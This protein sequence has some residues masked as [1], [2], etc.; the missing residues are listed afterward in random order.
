MPVS[1]PRFIKKAFATDGAKATI[2]DA[3]NNTTGRA[4][5]DQGF[6]PINMQPIE[7]GGIPPNGMDMNGI[8]YDM[9]LAIQ[10]V[11]SGVSFPFN[12][13]FATAIGGYA[14]GAIVSDLADK[15]S[16]WIN[17]TSNN[18]AF[19]AN[20]T[21]FK[22]GDP[23]E[24]V[25]G[26][27]FSASAADIRTGS[28]SAKM[29]SPSGLKVFGSDSG[30][31]VY[32]TPGIFTFTV[33]PILSNGLKKPYVTVIGAGGGC[34]SFGSTLSRGAS[35]GGCAEGLIDLSGV[36]TVS[37]TVGGNS[38][39]DGGSS[40]FGAYMTGP[41]GIAGK[42]GDGPFSPGSPG[43]GG[44]INRPGGSGGGPDAFYSGEGGGSVYSL[45]TP[46]SS[47]GLVGVWPGG[48]AGA[49]SAVNF[50]AVGAV[51]IQW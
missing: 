42:L 6:P 9:T 48:G 32:S 37:V 28:S 26:T 10:F 44:S 17:G 45:A 2:P 7:A 11:Q 12:Q 31:V 29:V 13:D 49:G 30:M 19:P 51:F 33:P 4:G 46:R 3:S 8:I 21:Q 20:W 47:S 5:Y 15:S 41:G 43:I 38:E 40:R 36:L 1:L 34:P 50:G 22:F 14:L 23:S 16:L 18:L 39:G 24:V 27:P 25:R 35:G